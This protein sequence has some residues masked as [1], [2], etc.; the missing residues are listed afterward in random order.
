MFPSNLPSSKENLLTWIMLEQPCSTL[1]QVTMHPLV[2]ILIIISSSP[3]RLLSYSAHIQ[4]LLYGENCHHSATLMWRI[5]QWWWLCFGVGPTLRDWL[6]SLGLSLGSF[7]SVLVGPKRMET[8]GLLGA[9]SHLLLISTLTSCWVRILPNISAATA[10]I[11]CTAT[12]AP[13][14]IRGS[15]AQKRSL[16]LWLYKLL[17][18]IKK[19]GYIFVVTHRV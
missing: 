2:A 17:P 12:I 1:Q 16:L 13:H 9:A 11:C 5:S 14:K 10:T 19:S 4:P 18:S 6:L 3:Q 15:I 7:S 8:L